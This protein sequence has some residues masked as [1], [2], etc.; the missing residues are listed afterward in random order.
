MSA[1]IPSHKHGTEAGYKRMEE[2]SKKLT[3][4][5]L[6]VIPRK[7]PGFNSW[8]CTKCGKKWQV[9]KDIPYP[10]LTCD[11]GNTTFKLG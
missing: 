1:K 9:A 4:K 2:L 8:T 3:E 6:L 10:S 5:K 11:C 7:H